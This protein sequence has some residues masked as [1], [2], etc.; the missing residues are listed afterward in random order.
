VDRRDFNG[1]EV[2]PSSLALL[3]RDGGL[4]AGCSIAA[5]GDATYMRTCVFYVYGC[6]TS[7]PA[8]QLETTQ[9]RRIVRMAIRD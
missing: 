4:I 8:K 5:L 9:N 1:N 6:P 7:V 3:L 2:I